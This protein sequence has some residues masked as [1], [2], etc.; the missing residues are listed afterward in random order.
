[1]RF[2]VGLVSIFTDRM[3]AHKDRWL[4]IIGLGMGSSAIYFICAE[5]DGLGRWPV[6][7]NSRDFMFRGYAASR[8]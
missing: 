4:S 7:F 3:I 8:P 1:M 6:P 5:D 2:A